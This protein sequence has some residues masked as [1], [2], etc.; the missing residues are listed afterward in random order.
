MIIAIDFDG[1]L[2]DSR[3]Q[4]LYKKLKK[5]KNEIW[6][7]TARKD[8]EFNRNILKPIIYKLF[9]PFSNIIFCND[10][11]KAEMLKAINADIYIDN[12]SNEFEEIS[13]QTNTIP[14]LWSNQ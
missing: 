6:I 12:I 5:E 2:T 3:I 1:T 10:K 7:V 13:N 11:P 8:N 14:L 9:V 4:E